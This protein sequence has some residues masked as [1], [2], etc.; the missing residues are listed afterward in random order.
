MGLL[1][2][3]NNLVVEYK[4]D[5]W[6]KPLSTTDTLAGTLGKENPF[7]YRGYLYDDETG[8]YYLRSRY[9]DPG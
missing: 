1:D 7:R 8:Y 9:Y 4:Y 5:A 2:S 3:A 6:G